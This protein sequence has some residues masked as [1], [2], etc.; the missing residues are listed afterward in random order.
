MVPLSLLES[1]QAS[2]KSQVE[3][4]QAAA[5]SQSEE[6]LAREAAALA[7]AK[8]RSG[9][10]L[11]R[12]AAAL[13]RESA[14]LAREAAARVATN[15]LK[16]VLELRLEDSKAS[17]TE[18][19]KALQRASAI[20]LAAFK[21]E[22]DVAR[23]HIDA[24][25]LVEE[26]LSRAWRDWQGEGLLQTP[27]Q[28]VK[29]PS[30]HT[31]RLKGILNSPGFRAYMEC[32]EADNHLTSGALTKC[33]ESMYSAL[34]NPVHSRGVAR[35]DFPYSATPPPV[36]MPVNSLNSI[37]QNGLA[38]FSAL[39]ASCGRNV[40]LYYSDGATVT[41]FMRAWPVQGHF[42]TGEDLQSCAMLPPV[43]VSLDLGVGPAN[44]SLQGVGGRG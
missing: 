30:I 34:C 31:E 21:F 6:A 25:V 11:A 40:G 7:A 16:T 20:E 42:A 3:S 9:E 37:G 4:L 35:G 22:R 10:A 18:R 28:V 38:A 12:E 39:L 33:A 43:A 29:I 36:Q 1:F 19:Y 23:G 8:S 14:A 5:K 15:E 32:V 44:P 2:A 26:S 27:P 13:A 24:R 17:A 41:L